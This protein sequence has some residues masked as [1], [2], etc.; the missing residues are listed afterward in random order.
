MELSVTYGPTIE[1][2]KKKNF[3]ITVR[4]INCSCLTL[5]FDITN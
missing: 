4:F 5:G 2:R 3:E 1:E